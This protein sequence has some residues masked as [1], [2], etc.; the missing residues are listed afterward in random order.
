M[1]PGYRH[2]HE[3]RPYPTTPGYPQGASHSH[4]L[5]GNR[6]TISSPG[7]PQGIAPTIHEAALRATLRGMG[8]TC[9]VGAIPCGRPGKRLE[10]LTL[11]RIGY[12]QGASLL[13][14]N[15]LEEPTRPW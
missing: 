14:T 4:Q 15:A 5:K 10:M 6:A 13:W 11:V 1:F 2:K 7:R 12:P 3:R 9:I 8:R